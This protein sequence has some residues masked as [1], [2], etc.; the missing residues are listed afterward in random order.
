MISDELLRSIRERRA[1]IVENVVGAPRRA[2]LSKVLL[3][4]VERV[5]VVLSSSRSGSSLL[6]RL[7]SRNKA[8]LSQ[9]GEHG[10]Y[11]RLNGICYPRVSSDRIDANFQDYD[12]ELLEWDILSELAVPDE[13]NRE[14]EIDRFLLRL[15]LQ[16]PLKSIDYES[17]KKRYLDSSNS[18]LKICLFS[19]L[20]TQ[21]YD[22]SDFGER[23]QADAEE[24]LA[25]PHIEETPFIF[26]QT[27]KSVPSSK[28]LHERILLLKTSVDAYRVEWLQSIFPNAEVK[29][30]HLTRNPA[31]TINGLI[32][33][34]LLNRGF[35][36]HLL[37]NLQIEEYPRSDYWNFDLP[38]NWRNF[39]KSRLT[40]VCFNQW[41]QPHRYII[42]EAP[43]ART[44][45]LQFEEVLLDPFRSAQRLSRFLDEE[46]FSF[47][48][49]HPVMATERPR[50]F[51]WKQRE[52]RILS[53][54]NN[55]TVEDLIGILDYQDREKWI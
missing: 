54:L 27:E 42:S 40:S 45:R 11:Y 13:N 39:T 30:I 50:I 33:G 20:P 24:P 52:R 18:L 7:L 47:F 28:D 17:L 2:F 46:M 4:E 32:D 25:E 14:D 38:P 55:E 16:F 34:W 26:S 49:I 48:S 5:C 31:A 22:L 41:E 19:Q 6:F 8:F 43:H 23:D 21:Y 35:Q 51:R 10:K 53:V 37:G 29:F 15:P 44:L 1:W 36:T 3:S 9:D 12:K